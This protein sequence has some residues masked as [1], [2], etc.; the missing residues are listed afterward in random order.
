[1]KP[2][3]LAIVSALLLG[4]SDFSAARGARHTS[5]ITVTRTS[6]LTSTLLAPLLFLVVPSSFSQRDSLL[7]AGSG[8]F[9]ILGLMLLYT[10]YS[11]ARMGVV[12]PLSSVLLAAVPV[13]WDVLGGTTPA[14]VSAAGMLLG[15]VAL[16]L[17][18]YTPGGEGSAA[19]GAVLGITSGISFG[20]AY[21][22]MSGVSADAGVSSVLLQRA[23]GLLLLFIVWAARHDPLFAPV[24]RARWYSIGAG[25]PGLI[26]IAALQ[27]AFQSV[28]DSSAG[29]VSVASSQ[30]GSVAVL[31]SVVFNGERMRWWQTI[32]VAT[33]ALAVALIALGG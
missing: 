5:A 2:I 6:V 7:A 9:M 22:F 31:L 23:A 8:I 25:V 18:S 12:A 28:Q 17:A 30:F 19:L 29:P 4:L 32:G 33:T 24:G 14:A 20:I 3:V 15:A 13:V 1:M 27:V 16:F 21:V 26:A 10:G 11:I